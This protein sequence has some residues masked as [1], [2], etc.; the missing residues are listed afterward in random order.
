MD[1]SEWDISFYFE[2]F[3]EQW[4]IMQNPLGSENHFWLI[5]LPSQAKYSLWDMVDQDVLKV[6][7]VMEN[8]L[9]KHITVLKNYIGCRSPYLLIKK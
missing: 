5:N 4:K 7:P 6:Y 3:D 2:A 1:K 9:Q 8:P